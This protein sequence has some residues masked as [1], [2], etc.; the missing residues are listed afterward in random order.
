M[1]MTCSSPPP[2]VLLSFPTDLVRA[3]TEV[4]HN[5]GF[6]S[7]LGFTCTK[8]LR[9]A[10]KS[11]FARVPAVRATASWGQQTQ[12]FHMSPAVASEY[13]GE[14]L[15]KKLGASPPVLRPTFTC[16]PFV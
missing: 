6:E 1:M 2:N 13:T 16:S 9:Q 4:K 12:G 10:T 5:P 8:M 11:L 14:P 15:P 7:R 3:H